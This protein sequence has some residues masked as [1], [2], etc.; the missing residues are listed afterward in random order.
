MRSTLVV[1]QAATDISLL[2]ALELRAAAGLADDDPS[3][4]SLLAL[5][6]R[7]S[8]S[9]LAAV[10]KVRPATGGQPTFLRETL[11]ET[12]WVEDYAYRAT[13]AGRYDLVLARRHGV[14]VDTLTI[15]GVVVDA[16]DYAVDGE[17]A[18]LMRTNGWWCGTSIVVV[19]RAGFLLEE[20]S[21]IEA[22]ADLVPDDL[23]YAA[24][25][26]VQQFRAMIPPT[27]R[28]QTVRGITV[29]GVG[30]V[31]YATDSLSTATVR[32]LV[33]DY[34]AALLGRYTNLVA[35]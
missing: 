31:Q 18:I 34:V 30:S 15:D 27:D 33:P 20:P 35:V 21:D 11:T 28:G 12:F 3:Q 5:Q 1:T 13:W 9:S 23:K 17:G 26:M 7:A 2:T 24:S 8:A 14:V 6:G 29:E 22:G 32:Q 19:Y 16:S 10:C 4:D 25:L